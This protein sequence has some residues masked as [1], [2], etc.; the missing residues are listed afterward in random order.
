MEL[1]L[2]KLRSAMGYLYPAYQVEYRQALLSNA[3]KPL[4]ELDSKK[5]QQY[6]RFYARYLLKGYC[7]VD[8]GEA[9]RKAID[10]NHASSLG[11]TKSLKIALQEDQRCLSMKAL[12]VK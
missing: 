3:L 8:S 9:L 1:A 5:D 7:T 4:V 11:T 12:V 2:A 10:D 6:L